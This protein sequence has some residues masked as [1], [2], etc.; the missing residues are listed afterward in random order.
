M[1]ARGRAFLGDPFAR[2]GVAFRLDA[3]LDEGQIVTISP[4]VLP[5]GLILIGVRRLPWAV[6][7]TRRLVE[8]HLG[9]VCAWAGVSTG[10]RTAEEILVSIGY[11]PQHAAEA[12]AKARGERV[13]PRSDVV[14]ALQLAVE[15]LGWLVTSPK[16][17]TV[18]VTA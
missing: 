4:D 5:G 7:E 18:R 1:S 6:T 11:T 2:M 13:R 8:Q 14:D 9:D 16:A 12:V 3:H 10:P 17:A 15:R